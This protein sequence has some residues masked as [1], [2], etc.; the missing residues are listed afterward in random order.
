MQE[1]RIKQKLYHKLNKEFEDDLT[2][3][4]I[5]LSNDIVNNAI[6][7][8]R[9]TDVGWIYPAKSYMVAICYAFWIMEDYDENFY[10]VL[11]YPELLPMDPYF[12]PYDKDSQTYNA[13]IS[14]VCAN[15]KGHLKL[16]GMVP[17]V[18]KYYDAEC[19]LESTLP[20]GN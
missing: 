9:E 7:Y 15:N 10:D 18:R 12:V 14:V 13:I 11:K 6:K 5:I 8:F 19:G 16:E 20:D 17:D 2:D 3:V 1:W 4:E